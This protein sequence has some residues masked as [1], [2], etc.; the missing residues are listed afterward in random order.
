M[1][2]LLSHVLSY[3]ENPASLAFFVNTSV[4]WR[5]WISKRTKKHTQISYHFIIFISFLPWFWTSHPGIPGEHSWQPWLPQG[6]MPSPQICVVLDPRIRPKRWA[7]LIATLGYRILF[8]FGCVGGDCKRESKG[9]AWDW[10]IFCVFTSILFAN[11][12]MCLDDYPMFCL[13][14]DD[15]SRFFLGVC[16]ESQVAGHG[17]A[18]SLWIPSDDGF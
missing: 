1:R 10:W 6:T 14:L 5:K 2:S 4:H 12:L 7:P 15:S 16:N 3:G 13:G 11:Y 18:N 9:K 8:G 17:C